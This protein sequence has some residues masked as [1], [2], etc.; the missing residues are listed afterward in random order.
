MRPSPAIHPTRRMALTLQ[1][2]INDQRFISHV[3][4]TN[5]RQRKQRFPYGSLKPK[6]RNGQSNDRQRMSIF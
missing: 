6:T 1:G 3:G 2:A 4:P 5:S